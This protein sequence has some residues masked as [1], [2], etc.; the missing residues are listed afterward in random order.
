MNLILSLLIFAAAIIV[1]I[2]LFFRAE[3]RRHEASYREKAMQTI[4]PNRLQAYERLT[5]YIERISPEAMVN[6]E[7]MKVKTAGE[8]YAVM[9]NTIKQEFE[10]NIAMQIYISSAS[11][12]RILRAREELIKM[13][14]EIAKTTNPKASSLE[15]GRQVIESAPNQTKFYFHRA[16]EGLRADINGEFISK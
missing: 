15:F 12:N 2:A 3:R 10:H 16:L 4:L 5:L 11:W 6:R 7:Q 13:L 9:M 14:K 8:L 1:V